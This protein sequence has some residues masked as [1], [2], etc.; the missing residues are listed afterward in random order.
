MKELLKSSEETMPSTA[1]TDVGHADDNPSPPSGSPSLRIPEHA[2]DPVAQWLDSARGAISH[3]TERALRSDLAI[4][5]AWCR[6]EKRRPWPARA[7]TLVRFIDH[8]AQSRAPATV[9]RYVSSLCALHRA[10]GW[11]NPLDHATVRMSLRRMYRHKGRRQTQALGLTWQIREKLIGSSGKPGEPFIG[12]P[13]EPGERLID[14]RNRAL[15]A[16]AYDAMLR[17]SELVTLRVSDLMFDHNGSATLFLKNAKTDP[18]GAGHMLF[19]ARDTADL[20]LAWLVGS[21]ISHGPLFRAVRKNGVPGG[22]LDPSQVSRI[23]KDMAVRAGFK[24]FAGG[25]SGHSAR[26]GATQDMI[27]SG[28]GLAAILQ[29]GRWKSAAMVSRYGERLLASRGAAAQLARMQGR[30]GERYGYGTKTRKDPDD[31]KR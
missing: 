10:A 5:L 21:G 11:K 3:N 14:I 6:K 1:W 24:D 17:R 9:R 16:V 4:W 23:Y 20:V 26:V 18:E 31:G 30:D 19:L 8:K 7:A 13:E 22:A 12:S 28:I 15:L 27:A 25:L 29:A 2:L